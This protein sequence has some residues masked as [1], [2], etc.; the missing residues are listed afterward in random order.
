[1][2]LFVVLLL[3]GCADPNIGRKLSWHP[4]DQWFNNKTGYHHSVLTHL[5]LDYDYKIEGDR[6]YFDGTINCNKDEV[7]DWNNASIDMNLYFMGEDMVIISRNHFSPLD[8]NDFCEQKPFVPNYPFPQGGLI[9]VR[10]NYQ[11]KM[12]Q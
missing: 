1:M 10:Y 2:L 9:G 7:H 12:W 6:I 8:T 3:S 5:I 4:S 11:V